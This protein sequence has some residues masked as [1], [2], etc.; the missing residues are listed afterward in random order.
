MTEDSL[1]I[2]HL[3]TRDGYDR[4]ATIYDDEENPLVAMEEPL[5]AE[6]LGDVRGIAVADL[7]CGTGRHTVRLAADGAVVTALDFSEAML[8][9]ARSKPGAVGVTFHVHDL[10]HPLPIADSSFDR[11]VCGLVVDHVADLQGFFAEMRRVCK[12]GGWAVVSTMHPAMMLRG[13]QARFTDPDTGR[14]TRPTSFRHQL[15]DYMLAAFR[16]GFHIDHLSEHAVTD[17][18]AARVP[19]AQKY[20]AWPLLFLMRLS[21]PAA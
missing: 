21:K 8:D 18:L 17:S 15:S 5:V 7:G 19:R 3:A 13:V 6:L 9:R 11:I 4:W 2:D 12:P 16:A 14:E 20:L 1:A 10:A